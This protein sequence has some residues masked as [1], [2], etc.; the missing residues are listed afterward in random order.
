MAAG[1]PTSIARGRSVEYGLGGRSV[2]VL[3]SCAEGIVESTP[4]SYAVAT[5]SHIP[6]Q[7]INY[8]PAS[9]GLFPDTQIGNK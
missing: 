6:F 7:F 2:R 3:L 1:P 9:R 8:R 5:S 4:A